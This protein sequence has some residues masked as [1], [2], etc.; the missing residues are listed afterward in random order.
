MFSKK[1]ATLKILYHPLENKEDLKLVL[2]AIDTSRIVLLGEGS[3]G[4]SEYYTWRAA[5]SK[6]LIK[7]KGFRIIAVEGDWSDCYKVNNFIK[8]EK[9]DSNAVITLLKEFN[10][11]PTWLWANYEVAS[12]VT[13][14]NE[15]NQNIP[16]NDKVGFYG[17]DL[18][19]IAEAADEILPFL[20]QAD[21]AT[22]NTVKRFQQCF[23][24]YA[25]D[26]LKYS[27]SPREIS[28]CKVAANNLWQ[29]VHALSS[30]KTLITEREFALDQ[31]AM[32][33]FDGEAYL[34]LRGNS[35]D[36]WNY[37]DNHMLET[38]NRIIKL[39]GPDAKIII[40]AHNNHVGDSRYATM[41][42]EGKVSLG[43]LLR[44]K[45]GDKNVFIVGAGS[46]SGNIIAA[47]K[48]GN[49]YRE[50]AIARAD[51]STWEQKM[52]QVNTKNKIIISNEV[53]DQPSMLRW[54]SHM[55]IGVT[56][57]PL[58]RTGIYTLS[59]IPN[60]YDA[61]LFFD[62]THALHPIATPGKEKGTFN[63]KSD[64]Y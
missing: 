64:D 55:G 24:N 28:A 20:E 13:W 46:Y 4:T 51:D 21:T 10:R 62:H 63:I 54:I 33:V 40:W 48:W 15:F 8:G 31:A 59:V 57:H 36:A 5:I 7:E 45:Y 1:E 35:V 17:L 6:R 12:L 30:Y 29:R 16:A 14:L 26:E 3:H 23:K 49:A 9:K 22:I 52:H 41:H 32:V 53:S 58:D 47:E 61:F 38:I 34:G 60:K 11:W 42:W 27:A 25:N 39:N 18:F 43:N 19:N 37:R 44:Q 2:N 50:M 56:Y